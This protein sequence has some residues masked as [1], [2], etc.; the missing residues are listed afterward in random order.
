MLELIGGVV[1]WLGVASAV[2]AGALGAVVAIEIARTVRDA[3]AAFWG[4]LFY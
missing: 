1:A 2:M 3:L 4:W